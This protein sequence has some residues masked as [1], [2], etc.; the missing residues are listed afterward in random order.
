M[1]LVNVQAMETTDLVEESDVVTDKGDH[2]FA[3]ELNEEHDYLI[4]Q[5]EDF[6]SIEEEV[7]HEEEALDKVE[8]VLEDRSVETFSD[9][10]DE[11][12]WEYTISGNK[13]IVKKYLGTDTNVVLLGEAD[14]AGT[15]YNVSL[16]SQF[17]I[18]EIPNLESFTIKEVNGKKVTVEEQ[19]I[20]RVS[21]S[22]MFSESPTVKK[23]DLRG[24]DASVV[25][26]MSRAF[27][28][29]KAMTELDTTGWDTSNV[30]SMES[31][32]SNNVSLRQVDL[33]HFDMSKVNTAT[34]MFNKSG[35]EELDLSSWNTPNF[36]RV[37]SMFY[38]M[39]N[40]K[41]LNV[42][43]WI[44]RD[45]QGFSFM[46]KGVHSLE[47][48][49]LSSWDIS[50]TEDLSYMFYDSSIKHI[51]ISGWDT[52]SVTDL[53]SAF[54]D[55][56]KLETLNVEGWDT[57]NV[58]IMQSLF[59]GSGIEH[60]DLS[61]W[62]TESLL[63][64]AHIFRNT[65][66]LKT[67]GI[68]NWD[69][70]NLKV[71]LRGFENASSVET[72]DL[73]NWETNSL[74]GIAGAFQGMS[75]LTDL[76][77]DGFKFVPDSTIQNAFGNTENLKVIDLS[78]V[79]LS[80]VTNMINTFISD[81]P[82]AELLVISD[83]PDIIAYDYEASNRK[84]IP[85]GITLDAGTGAFSDQT[86]TKTLADKHN[87]FVLSNRY[88][89]EADVEAFIAQ[90][91]V[92]ED[93]VFKGWSSDL[94]LP[95]DQT[96]GAVTLTATYSDPVVPVQTY[97]VRFDIDGVISE[98]EVVAG[99]LIRQDQLPKVSKAGYT[100]DGF[101]IKDSN[102]K[103]MFDYKKDVVTSDLDLVAVFS[104]NADKETP[105]TGLKS[106]EF[107][108]LMTLTAAAAMIVILKKKKYNH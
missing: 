83:H 12:E 28:N 93:G 45:T 15:A 74:G 53:S 89:S 103:V 17:R 37:S 1:N 47:S 43:G 27:A 33:S 108:A 24:L 11:N 82:D 67:M 85:V 42:D 64:A 65:P 76:N 72:L 90:I 9:I 3:E 10:F 77:L 71:L 29:N 55:T 23:L 46:F 84:P 52:S 57:S 51:N 4:E 50:G 98:I 60:V 32:F 49:D 96:A 56:P 106:N 41:S 92:S 63:Y 6:E 7:L 59:E 54:R 39:P 62:N 107:A 58:Q 78:K 19:S 13:I 31:M 94:V 38:E 81:E 86:K 79:D 88:L 14:I 105:P 2:E 16:H 102:P 18:R 80:N 70:R 44:M 68:E 40:L 101:M 69:V 100:F 104:K 91:P 25:T 99:S 26:D 30:L 34:S 48:V 36:W 8:D 95:F 20:L 87:D 61:S 21:I 5:N 75:S 73:S 97:T 66:N 22:N 35:I